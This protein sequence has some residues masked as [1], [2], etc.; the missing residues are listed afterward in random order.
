MKKHKKAPFRG[1]FVL[2]QAERVLFVVILY[3]VICYSGIVSGV[4]YAI[5]SL[6]LLYFFL[7]FVANSLCFHTSARQP[8]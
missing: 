3:A 1:F 7:R 2:F 6:I 8:T 5:V 4:I